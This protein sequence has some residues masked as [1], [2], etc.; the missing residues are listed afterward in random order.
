VV[1]LEIA[2]LMILALTVEVAIL[3]GKGA[4]LLLGSG[5]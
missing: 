2:F 4:S 5:G 3:I 1:L